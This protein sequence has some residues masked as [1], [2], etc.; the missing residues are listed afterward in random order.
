M[1]TATIRGVEAVPVEVQADVSSGL[2]SF[3]I[4][5]LADAAVMEARDRVRSAIR[6]CGFEFPSARVTIN[7]APAP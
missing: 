3:T 6:T 1:L 5:G 2:P 7:L 4:V